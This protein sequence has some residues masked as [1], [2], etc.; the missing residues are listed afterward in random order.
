M[1]FVDLLIII[2]ALASLSRGYQIG[3]VR[4]LGSTVGFV[5]GLFLGAWA[6]SL[7]AGNIADDTTQALVSLLLVLFGG[8]LFMTLG[9]LASIRIKERLTQI[10]LLHKVD[11]ALGSAMSIVTVLFA[12]WLVASILALGP[13]SSA[14]QAVKDSRIF[15]T[16]NSNLPPATS[17]LSSLNKLI[18]PN[19]F[20][21]VFSGREPNPTTTEVPSLGS[22]DAVV[23]ST[24]DSV[25]KVQ[26]VGCG[27]IVEGTGFV[28]QADR[29]A[30]N[31]HVVAGV[32]SPKVIDANGIH[33]TRVVW[34]DPDLDLAVLQVSDLAGKPLKIN[35]NEQ[36]GGTPAVVL[37]YPG[38]GDFNAQ[39]AAIVDRFE[40]YGRNIYNQGTTVR[41][42]YSLRAHVIPGNSGGPVI[43]Q[44]G[45]VVAI[46]FATS[47][48]YN[49]IGY[50]LTGHQ[51][52]GELATAEQSN[53]THS[54]GSCSE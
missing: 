28:V 23:A 4:Q 41:D 35:A 27:G 30:T 44:D 48:T 38:G 24:R 17:L 11:G 18:D 1:N 46:V 5:V 42:V 3:F 34:F 36:P 50:A 43:G 7:I 31:A 33:N 16:L 21:E 49:S 15:T 26:G 13:T 51:V 22:F 45:Q 39:A 6:S 32:V 53:T 10:N 47:T 12:F 25:V 19:S 2:I 52:A 40:A 14:Q 29:V 20:P 54:T 37:G 9:E 8:F